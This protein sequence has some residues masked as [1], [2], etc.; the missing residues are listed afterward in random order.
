M[1]APTD[2][3]LAS[4]G[5]TLRDAPT[6]NEGPRNE[7]PRNDLE[8]R[9]AVLIKHQESDHRYFTH[10]AITHRR[11]LDKLMQASESDAR[12]MS[13]IESRLESLEKR[14]GATAPPNA[15]KR[16][17]ARLDAL[18]KRMDQQ[19][20]DA[21]VQTLVDAAVKKALEG[22]IVSEATALL[23][24][25]MKR[26][27]DETMAS[28]VAKAKATREKRKREEGAAGASAAGASSTALVVLPAEADL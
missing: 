14:L 5:A 6:R 8:A 4:L 21:R 2:S 28:R 18:S 3:F 11:H 27:H 25:E 7:G 9:L 20:S 22:G 12:R 19:E 17:D 24:A 23:E 26:R 13:R 10:T 1:A 16:L 15:E